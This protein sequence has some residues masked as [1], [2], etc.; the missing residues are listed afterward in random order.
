[1]AEN[2]PKLMT[3]TKIQVLVIQ[4]TSEMNIKKN[5]TSNH[6]LFKLQ[7]TKVKN[8]T[9]KVP[10][11]KQNLPIEERGQKLKET[12]HRKPAN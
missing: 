2:C 7:K 8:N 9:L 10:R 11:L 12:Y 1:M 4:R 3:D 5:I 6:I